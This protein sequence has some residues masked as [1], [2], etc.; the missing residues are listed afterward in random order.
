MIRSVEI[1]VALLVAAF[2]GLFSDVFFHFPFFNYLSPFL[3]I[4]SLCL[5]KKTTP[6]IFTIIFPVAIILCLL[7][8]S[9]YMLAALFPLLGFLFSGENKNT[10]E[11]KPFVRN[12]LL[13]SLYFFYTIY[14]IHNN[15]GFLYESGNA[16]HNYL[17]V[18]IVYAIVAELLYFGKPSYLYI[19]LLLFSFV[20]LGNRSSMYL[21]AVFIKS[22]TVLITFILIG[23]IFSGIVYQLIPP[24]PGLEVLFNVGGLLY[25]SSQDNRADLIG[26]FIGNFDISH[27]AYD[28]WT[29]YEIPRTADGFYDLHNSFMTLIVRDSYLGIFKDILWLVQIAFLPLGA[30]IGITMR[31]FNDTFLLG[32]IYDLLVYALIGRSFHDFF[33]R[34]LTQG[35]CRPSNNRRSIT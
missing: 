12:A 30:F 29:F 22:K 1:S 18:L 24:P 23:A 13:I 6:F 15:Q 20:V 31:A 17:T 4:S 7:S 16:S 14:Y 33:R 11:M 9:P 10:A 34:K 32:G 2:V 27:L 21:L 8:F 19:P 35:S 5:Y 28:N 25:R 3:L 26:Q